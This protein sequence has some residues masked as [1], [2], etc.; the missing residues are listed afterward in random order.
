[1]TAQDQRAVVASLSAARPRLDR[2]DSGRDTEDLAADLIEAWS[3]TEGALRSIMGGSALAGQPLIGALRQKNLL[4]LDQAHAL[5]EFLAARDR[6]QRTE[7][8]P[9]TGDIAAAREG[10]AKLEHGIIAQQMGTPSL[11][12]TSMFATVKSPVSSRAQAPDTAPA[13]DTVVRRRRPI[14]LFIPVLLLLVIAGFAAWYFITRDGIPGGVASGIAAYNAGRLDMARGEFEVAARKN[15]KLALPH[16]WLGRVARD[17]REDAQ[18][19]RELAT[20]ERL[21]PGNPLVHREIGAFHLARGRYNE[22]RERY[23][24]ALQLDPTDKNAQGWLACA[25]TRLGRTDQAQTWLNHAGPG[26]WTRCAS[27]P[28]VQPALP[29]G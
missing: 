23:V 2:L 28:A 14:P 6:A 9:T 3:A 21:E 1:M 16:I 8:R 10:F 17:Q 19:A 5:L 7:Y 22:A 27:A 15:D 18:A 11:A 20:A 13:A 29:P 25:L 26:D 12:D 4:S 24:R